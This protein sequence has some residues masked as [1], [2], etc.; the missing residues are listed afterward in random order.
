MNEYLAR[1]MG[2]SMQHPAS[3]F[4]QSPSSP[5]AVCASPKQPVETE[6]EPISVTDDVTPAVVAA[7]EI[8]R[9]SV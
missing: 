6:E 8:H 4:L 2:A 3:N 9:K 7:Q 1:L 5:E